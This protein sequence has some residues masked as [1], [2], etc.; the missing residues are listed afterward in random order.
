MTKIIS[1]FLSY[2]L[3][4]FNTNLCGAENDNQIKIGLLAPF[5]G[6]YKNLGDSLLF[7]TQLAL[8]EIGDK[9]IVIIPRDSGSD[10][11]I[12]LNLAVKELIADGVKV[13]IGPVDSK[14]FEELYKYTLGAK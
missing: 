3:I 5:S 10:D 8:S 4:T 1:I 6:Q 14:N 11:K 13:V 7:S 12:K 9:N 2:L